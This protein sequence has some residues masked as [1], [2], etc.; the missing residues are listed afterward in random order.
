MLVS[1]CVTQAGWKRHPQCAETK[2]GAGV[3][4]P[5]PQPLRVSSYF[6]FFLAAFFLAAMV[7]PPHVVERIG[8]RRENSSSSQL[9]RPDNVTKSPRMEESARG[10]ASV[11]ETSINGTGGDTTWRGQCQAG[12]VAPGVEGLLNFFQVALRSRKKGGQWPPYQIG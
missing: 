5:R 3:S 7:A 9:C 4:S 2:T 11:L 6:F 1:H 10:L 12:F 8:R